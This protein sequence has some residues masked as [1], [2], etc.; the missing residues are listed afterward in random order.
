MSASGCLARS[1][2][3]ERDGSGDFSTIAAALA[4][5]AA[6]D[7]ILI[8][9]GR[10]PEREPFEGLDWSGPVCIKVPVTD[11]T[12]IGSGA[13]ST[14]IGP[15]SADFQDEGPK[16]IVAVTGVD[17][18]T[19]ENLALENV[20]DGV[21]WA[22][23]HLIL[24]GC[25]LLAC[26]RGISSQSGDGMLVRS[27]QFASCVSTG[28]VAERPARNV[29][30]GDSVFHDCGT[31]ISFHGVRDANLLGCTLTGG[32]IGAQ[33]ADGSNGGILESH[34]EDHQ[35]IGID[36]TMASQVLL[37]DDR[38]RGG[39]F[40]LSVSS[41]SHVSGAD[42]VLRGGAVATVRISDAAMTFSGNRILNGGEHSVLLESFLQ[43]PIVTIDL[44]S[45]FWGTLQPD[46]IAAW[47]WDHHDDPAIQAFVAFEP[48][49][50][51]L[52]VEQS[53]WG[54]VKA[55]YW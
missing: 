8:G 46:T 1:W 11:L 39:D 27:C 55:R 51:S 18:L 9:P 16:G 22:R 52:P 44:T 41:G 6:Q 54:K 53:S 3:V 14:I 2:R 42:N 17:R 38:I 7:T 23:G 32:M 50:A 20:Y 35:Q 31:G 21:Y 37:H 40:N 47:I 29:E 34:F 25:S 49:D 24:H 45:N 15:V 19:V 33:Y 36:V 30:V 13:E 43:P 10:Y 26:E 4:A 5:A 12:L 48:F 28:I